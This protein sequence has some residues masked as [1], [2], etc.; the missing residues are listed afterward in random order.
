MR[1]KICTTCGAVKRLDAFY[2]RKGAVGGRHGSC[3]ECRDAKVAAW[4]ES[5]SVEYNAKQALRSQKWRAENPFY[6]SVDKE[7]RKAISA[8]N[9]E[10]YGFRL[11]Y[12]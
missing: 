9:R 10:Y 6:A 7:I 12:R 5:H 11:G 4:R 3:K 1:T 2:R 8:M